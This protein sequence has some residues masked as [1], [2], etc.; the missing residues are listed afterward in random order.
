VIASK[1]RIPP[2]LDSIFTAV[3]SVAVNTYR[4]GFSHWLGKQCLFRQTCSEHALAMLR[5]SGWNEGMGEIRDR[6]TR[7]CGDFRIR[8]DGNGRLELE[9]VDGL[10]F[11]Q[12]H[13][14]DFIIGQ[15][16]AEGHWLLPK[17]GQGS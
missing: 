4:L 10:I 6:L 8:I 3:A 17:D 1:V 5:D 9:T 14:S 16:S 15:Y 12:D 13:L 7:C 11:R 2:W